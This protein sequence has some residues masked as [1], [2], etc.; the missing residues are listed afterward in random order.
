[1]KS[2]H[3]G[4]RAGAGKPKGHKA[5]STLTKEMIRAR[6][7][8]RVAA[9]LDPLLDAQIAN[10]KGIN[11]LVS[12]DPKSGKFTP[13][14]DVENIGDATEIWFK[15]PNVQAFTDLMNRAADKPSEHVQIT[16]KDDEPVTFRWQS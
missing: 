16:G 7:Q 8:A 12:R 6:I 11:Y 3:G 15:Q 2:S 5:H 4:K 9:E 14:E 10:A 13:I 1:M